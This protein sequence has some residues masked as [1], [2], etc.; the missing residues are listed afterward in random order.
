MWHNL[1]GNAKALELV[2]H[3][4]FAGIRIIRII[5]A[6]PCSV[7]GFSDS[8]PAVT[9]AKGQLLSSRYVFYSDRNTDRI[10]NPII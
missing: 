3:F 4:I 6:Y 2:W 5:S 7:I 10:T 8:T 1:G 9:K